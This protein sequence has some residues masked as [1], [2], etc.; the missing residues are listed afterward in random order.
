MLGQT[1]RATENKAAL[2]IAV[3]PVG[4]L[5]TPL[6]AHAAPEP[7]YDEHAI[8][9]HWPEGDDNKSARMLLQQEIAAAAE[10]V[11]RY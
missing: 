6:K 3:V 11:T 8:I 7:D 5:P 10:P 4:A 2:A 9:V 1:I